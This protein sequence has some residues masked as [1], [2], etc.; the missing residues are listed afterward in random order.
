[1]S[2]TPSNLPASTSKYSSDLQ[3]VLSRAIAIA[4]LPLNQLNSQLTTLQ[5]RS[6]ALDALHG[7]FTALQS[8]L[9]GVSDAAVST[10][11]QVSDSSVISAQSSPTATPGSYTI[12]VAN[13]GAH[14]SA[15][16]QDGLPA[17]QDPSTQSISAAT[18]FT[19]TVGAALP[20]TITPASNT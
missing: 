5:N 17:V 12:H 11:A 18:S 20:L 14:S 7:K 13:A 15:L 8:A 4:S 9:Q 10:L 1:M 16:S 2:S 6:S 19:L 3:Q